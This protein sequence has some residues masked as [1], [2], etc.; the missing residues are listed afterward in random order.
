MCLSLEH[1]SKTTKIFKTLKRWIIVANNL[2]F[3]NN[4]ISLFVWPDYNE[5]VVNWYF[6]EH[7]DLYI[8]NIKQMLSVILI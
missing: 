1:L 3:K 6:I 8:V 7:G 5:I 4:Q 2:V